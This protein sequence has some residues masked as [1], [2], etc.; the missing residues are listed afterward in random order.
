MIKLPCPPVFSYKQK[1]K[2]PPPPPPQK[3]KKKKRKKSNAKEVT[4]IQRWFRNLKQ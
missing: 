2:Q 4:Q 1:L 3:K